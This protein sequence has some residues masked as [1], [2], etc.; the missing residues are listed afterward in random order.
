MVKGHK[1]KT[2][3]CKKEKKNV[4]GKKKYF[5][6][7]FIKIEMEMFEL[8]TIKSSLHPFFSFLSKGK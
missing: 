7:N 6:V 3:K 5:K 8:E 1:R 2:M 4:N